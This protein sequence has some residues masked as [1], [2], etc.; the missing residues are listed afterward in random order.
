MRAAMVLIGFAVLPGCSQSEGKRA[1]QQLEIVM[2]THPTKREQC[3]EKR[4][5]ADAYLRDQKLDEYKMW[6]MDA[7]VTCNGA[8]I[9]DLM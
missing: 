1:E 7:D 8:D 9:D 3:T 4:K 2:Q 5:V 6:D